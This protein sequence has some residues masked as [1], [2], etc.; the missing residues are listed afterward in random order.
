LINTVL[1][2]IKQSAPIMIKPNKNS[3]TKSEALFGES[4][5]ILNIKNNWVYGKLKTDNYLGWIKIS[6]LGSMPKLTHKIKVIRTIAFSKPNIKSYPIKYLPLGSLISSRSYNDIWVEIKYSN[7]KVE[8][9]G[10]VFKKHIESIN[11]VNIDWVNTA[12]LLIGTPYKWGGRDSMGLDCSA[13]VQLC[14]ST[15]NIPFPR[16]TKDQYKYKSKEVK[17]FNS[18]KRGNLIFWPGHVA[19]VQNSNNLIHANAFHMNVISETIA[20]A[21]KRIEKETG[22][23]SKI[24]VITD[25]A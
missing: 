2:I 9:R 21:T 22:S 12:E 18:I 13:L 10:Y 3:E 7:T 6:D 14:L 16:D 1:Q 8:Q 5:L 19:I 15:A 23:L 11:Y 17:D 25:N 24:K 20:V 4:F